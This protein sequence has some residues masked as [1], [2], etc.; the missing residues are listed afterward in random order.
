[1]GFDS[2]PQLSLQKQQ[3][4][5]IYKL[6]SFIYIFSISLVIIFHYSTEIDLNLNSNSKLFCLYKKYKVIANL[7]CLK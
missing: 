5:I 7:I 1:M 2:L 4:S 6:C 3:N